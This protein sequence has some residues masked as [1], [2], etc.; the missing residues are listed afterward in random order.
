MNGKEGISPSS[1]WDSG[2]ISHRKI[3]TKECTDRNLECIVLKPTTTCLEWRVEK[4]CSYVYANQVVTERT[5]ECVVFNLITRY[6]VKEMYDVQWVLLNG[7][8][9]T[10]M[11]MLHSHLTTSYRF[12]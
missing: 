10:N 3:R 12:G 7:S 1:H 2:N 4:Q 9:K 11:K 6:P 8:C 5:L